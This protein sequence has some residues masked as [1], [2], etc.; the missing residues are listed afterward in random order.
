MDKSSYTAE[1]FVCDE[2]FRNY[3]LGS[4]ETAVQFWK[5]WIQDHPGKAEEVSEA[6]R[7]FSILNARQG[8]VQEQLDQLKDGILRFDML[9]ATIGEA[10]EDRSERRRE[11]AGGEVDPNDGRVD[12]GDKR[13]KWEVGWRYGMGIAAALLVVAAAVWLLVPVK[14]TPPDRRT[15][16]EIRSGVEP[17]KTVV[18]PDGSV[19]T[20]HSNTTLRLAEGFGRSGRELTLSGEALFDIAHGGDHPFIVH[21][22]TIDVEVL[23]TLFNLNAYPQMGYTEASLFRG[24]IAVSLKDHPEKKMVLTPSQ[25]S[26]VFNRGNIV[27][28][29]VVA[30]SVLKKV[31][32]SVDPVDHKAKEIAWVRNR[33][34]IEDEP[35]ASIAARLQGWYGIPIVFTDNEVKTYR[36]SGTFESE[37]VVKALEALQL[38]YPFNFRVERDTIIIGK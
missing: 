25:K 16:Y 3:C 30:D 10:G 21:T 26:V 27:S 6:Q 36:Y 20:L 38:S 17:R 2:S 14:Q 4:D 5:T 24:K 37:T 15:A 1:D 31:S 33:I 9:K 12:R 29:D 28:P 23:G 34:R 35:L 32:L 7:L 18:L 11:R 13:A 19:V 22:S 8:N